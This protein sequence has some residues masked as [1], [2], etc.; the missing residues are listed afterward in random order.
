MD[1]LYKRYA[2]P[3]SLLDNLIVN[4][5]FNEYVQFLLNK[6]AEEKN[7]NMLWE[8]F[9]HKVYNKSFNEWKEEIK[10]KSQS[11]DAM[12]EAK[13]EEII[14]KSN[15]ILQGFVPQPK[16]QKGGNRE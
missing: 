1:L 7:D 13:K 9:L 4:E 8:F 3:F 10:S 12:N 2:S 5:Q 16:E 11:K 6:E 15:A 14:A